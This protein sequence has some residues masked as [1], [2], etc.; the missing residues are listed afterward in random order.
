MKQGDGQRGAGSVGV[1][2]ETLGLLALTTVAGLGPVLIGRAVRHFGSSR[3][4]WA[5]DVTSLQ[6]IAGMGSKRAAAIITARAGNSVW[7]AARREIDDAAAAGARVVGLGEAEYPKLLAEI[8]D[9]PPV[10]YVRG[11]IKPQEHD[12]YAL[13]M[14]GSRACTQYGREQT[15]RFATMLASSGLTIISG[16]ARGI[17]TVAHRAAID[18]GGRTIV[19][20][21]CGISR[22]YPP[23]NRDLFDRIVAE[24]RGAIVSEL[25][26]SAAPDAQNFPARNRLISGMSLGVLVIEA[27]KG[28]G[29]LI[30]ARLAAEDQ[31]REVFAVPGR[32]DSPASEGTNELLRSGGAELVTSPGEV[33]ESL[34]S[35]A[36]HVFGGTHEARY[37][38]MPG[39]RPGEQSG[40]T[41][42]LFD[43]PGAGPG[44]RAGA[45]AVSAVQ[46]KIL[47][48]LDEA[49]DFD[50]LVRVTGLEAGVIAGELT[51]LEVRRLVVRGGGRIERVRG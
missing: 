42:G 24:D 39:E 9:P 29:S 34:R 16:G 41:G 31:G 1:P 48:A 21:G 35:R 40:Q 37:G 51:M 11:R 7:D 26:V 22:A 19:V 50:A 30:S 5:A 32:V 13:A 14:V 15:G 18:A 49:K 6:A 3:A 44:G 36:E 25:P 33:L 43:S 27:A 28:S 20:L 23:E 2:E 38:L 10:L 46:A 47:A 8:A 12:R 17:D 45:V 4:V